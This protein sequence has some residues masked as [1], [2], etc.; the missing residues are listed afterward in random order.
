MKTRFPARAALVTALA[1]AMGAPAFGGDDAPRLLAQT[2]FGGGGPGSSSGSS[3]TSSPGSSG[4]A[5]V[6]HSPVGTDTT[7]GTAATT[8]DVRTTAPGTSATAPS[9]ASRGS[10]A[11]ADM[12]P[13]DRMQNW[14]NEHRPR[15]HV[16]RSADVA[17]Y[18]TSR[19]PQGWGP[20][21]QPGA[22]ETAL[23]PRLPESDNAQAQ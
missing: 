2:T 1:L 3:G 4:S 21:A 23:T 22:S 12:N 6:P 17:G 9:D 13:V 14:W 15:W 18:D 5:T 10:R 20:G 11:T 19:S 7:R 8:G 16:P